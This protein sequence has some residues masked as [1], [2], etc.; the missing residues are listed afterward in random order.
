M[1]NTVMKCR[2]GHE[3]RL[4]GFDD[5]DEHDSRRG[6]STDTGARMVTEARVCEEAFAGETFGWQDGDM[7]GRVP[8]DSLQQV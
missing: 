1:A 2:D 4:C 7:G 8:N 3:H 6:L 5:E